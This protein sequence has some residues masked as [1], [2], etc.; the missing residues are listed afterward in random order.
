ML[1]ARMATALREHTGAE[2]RSFE[3][4]LRDDRWV[5]VFDRVAPGGS[6]VLSPG[7]PKGARS[8]VPLRTGTSLVAVRRDGAGEDPWF[9]ADMSARDEGAAL[10]CLE[11]LVAAQL[12]PHYDI[13]LAAN[14]FQHASEPADAVI[15]LRADADAPVPPYTPRFSPRRHALALTSGSLLMA[16][17][18]YLVGWLAVGVTQTLVA[19]T[20]TAL[21]LAVVA[22][23]VPNLAAMIALIAAGAATTA[24]ASRVAIAVAALALLPTVLVV[25][26]FPVGAV[27]GLVGGMLLLVAAVLALGAPGRA[28]G[29][30]GAFAVIGVGGIVAAS[31]LPPAAPAVLAGAMLLGTVVSALLVRAGVRAALRAEPVDPAA[32]LLS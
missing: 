32:P 6:H 28:W 29:G 5:G 4:R 21:A 16:L 31:L 30:V 2:P 1:A 22:A 3:F 9:A 7:N 13:V 25:A 17:I 11:R 24:A 27:L 14:T 23:L 26:P 19:G 12:A 8:P 10:A 18:A 20:P 15:D